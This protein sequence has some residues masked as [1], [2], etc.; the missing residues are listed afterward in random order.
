[1]A[2]LN[3]QVDPATRT[4]WITSDWWEFGGWRPSYAVGVDR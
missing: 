2:I 1:M 3:K 4:I